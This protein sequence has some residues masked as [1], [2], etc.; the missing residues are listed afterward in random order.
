MQK[1]KSPYYQAE[2]G[3]RSGRLLKQEEATVTALS[4]DN[5]VSQSQQYQGF[6]QMFVIMMGFTFFSPSMIAGGQLGLGLNMK[7][8]VIALVVGNL[9]LCLYTGL[10]GYIGQKT[11]MSLDALAMKSFGRKGSYIPS[12]IIGM[13]QMGWTGVGLAMFALPVAN[14]LSFNPYLLVLI[15]GVLVLAT[16]L[17]GVKGLAVLGSVAVP[18]ILILGLYST[19]VSI[20]AVGGVS[21]LF[22]ESPAQPLTMSAALAIVIGNFISGGTATP[23]FTRYGKNATSTLLATGIAFFIGNI[24]MFVFGASGAAA[25]GKADI[26]DVLI[27]QGLAIPGILSLGF[28]IWTTNNNSLYTAG[29]SFANVSKLSFKKATII[30]GVLATC[31]AIF[32]YNNFT[33]YLSFLGAMI[34]PIGGI[35]IAHYFMYRESYQSQA[36]SKTIDYSAIIALLAGVLIGS[37]MTWGIAC[38][39]S[40]FITILVYVVINLVNKKG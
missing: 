11:G 38:L 10:L 6:W 12:I 2:L 40:L 5:Y 27:L 22:S 31:L 32:L 34:P 13:T 4:H 19:Q 9:F 3:A 16:T 23:N 1:N 21:Q 17:Y 8:F 25:F 35:I 36:I 26:F 18:A 15:F 33:A 20:Q 30:M 28:N 37:L 7:N 29:L 39:N 24:L 14:F